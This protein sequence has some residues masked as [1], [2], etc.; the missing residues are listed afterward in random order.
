MEPNRTV[1]TWDSICSG[2]KFL[3]ESRDEVASVVD[4]HVEASEAVHRSLDGRLGLG[5]VRDVQ[6]DDEEVLVVTERLLDHIGVAAGGHDRMS[7]FQGLAGYVGAHSAAGAGDQ[8]S[9]HL[10]HSTFPFARSFLQESTESRNLGVLPVCAG[11]EI[12]VYETDG[13]STK[14]KVTGSGQVGRA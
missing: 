13:Q 4:E 10:S 14:P 1:R 7:C 6:A 12:S 3:E 5:G 2:R 9:R 11:R 8:P